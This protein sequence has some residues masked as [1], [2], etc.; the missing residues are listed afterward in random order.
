MGT[1]KTTYDESGKEYVYLSSDI[2]VNTFGYCGRFV[3]CCRGKTRCH[4][5]AHL[6]SL[7]FC[8]CVELAEVLCKKA[9]METFSGRRKRMRNI[10]SAQM[11]ISKKR[12]RIFHH[13]NARKQLLRQKNN[14]T[15]SNRRVDGNSS[16]L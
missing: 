10:N 12:N 9:S 3:A 8:L 14:N 7:V 11:G 4:T 1:K 5:P 6:K 16:Q 13:Y 15:C 2:T